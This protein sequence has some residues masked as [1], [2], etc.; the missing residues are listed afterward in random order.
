MGENKFELEEKLKDA[1]YNRFRKSMCRFM[2]LTKE[3]RQGWCLWEMYD[4]DYRFK[5]VCWN[6]ED[7]DG[8]VQPHIFQIWPDGNGFSEYAPKE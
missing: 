5:L 2:E 3:H 8:K 7:E 6:M 4:P 1:A